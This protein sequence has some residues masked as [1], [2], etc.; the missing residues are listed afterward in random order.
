MRKEETTITHVEL[1]GPIEGRKG[2]SRPW[3]WNVERIRCGPR[4]AERTAKPTKARQKRTLSNQNSNALF[5]SNI[6]RCFKALSRLQRQH[7][8]WHEEL[9]EKEFVRH[10]TDCQTGMASCS[11]WLLQ[12]HVPSTEPS[13]RLS[14]TPS[15]RIG[16]L[17]RLHQLV[18]GKCRMLIARVTDTW[19]TVWQRATPCSILY[20][21]GGTA[22]VARLSILPCVVTSCLTSD[23]LSDKGRRSTL[24]YAEGTLLLRLPGCQ[25]IDRMSLAECGK[26]RTHA[27]TCA[28]DATK[29]KDILQPYVGQSPYTS[30]HCRMEQRGAKGVQVAM[31]FARAAYA[32]N[33]EIRVE[34]CTCV[35]RIKMCDQAT[36][37]TKCMRVYV[38]YT[39]VCVHACACISVCVCA[40]A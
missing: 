23:R 40:C 2:Q 35:Q 29:C 25:F 17:L 32:A 14:D 1:R 24:P 31:L 39:C 10:L 13:D 6:R 27:E 12:R 15:C 37:Q 5:Q 21:Q 19:E 28:G 3:H 7:G 20:Q 18:L 36:D 8:V 16:R 4:A 9:S 38:W 22:V 30:S 26:K 34:F 11:G 33:G